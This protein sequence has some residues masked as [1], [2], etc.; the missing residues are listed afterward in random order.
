MWLKLGKYT[1]IPLSKHSFITYDIYNKKNYSQHTVI[2]FV[3]QNGM[4]NF[5][6]CAQH[7]PLNIILH[8][9]I[10]I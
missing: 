8:G 6:F 1:C 9:D 4:I 2:E 5:E 3:K 7:S 10:G